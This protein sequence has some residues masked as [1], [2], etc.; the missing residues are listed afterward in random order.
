MVIVD[1]RVVEGVGIDQSSNQ[2]GDVPN[3][4]HL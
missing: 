3:P 2:H 1:K 4:V